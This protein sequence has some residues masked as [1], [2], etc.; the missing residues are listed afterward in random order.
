MSNSASFEAYF[1][2]LHSKGL[3]LQDAMKTVA[4]WSPSQFIDFQLTHQ[5]R[6]P[7][8]RARESE[9]TIADFVASRSMSGGRWPC[10]AM[11]CRMKRVDQLSRFIALYANQ[12]VIPSPI[13]LIPPSKLHENT[14]IEFL[15]ELLVLYAFKPLLEAGLLV[16]TPSDFN[17]CKV[18][19]RK[20]I[21]LKK[22][23]T[24][25]AKATI[26]PNL[27]KI[28]ITFKRSHGVTEVLFATPEMFFDHSFHGHVTK[29]SLR[30]MQRKSK[31]QHMLG[32]MGPAISDV[33]YQIL[34]G[35]PSYLSSQEFDFQLIQHLNKPDAQLTSK[36]LFD[37]FSHS[38]PFVR[39]V[40]IARLLE[41]RL[42]EG[43]SFKVYRDAVDKSLRIAAKEDVSKIKQLFSD[44][45]LPELN[46]IDL[47]I[48]NSRS[49]FAGS[50]IK[51]FAV[52][53]GFLGVGLFAGFVPP[54]VS[55][56]FTALGGYSFVKGAADQISDTVRKPRDIRDNK[57][58]FL[59]KVRDDA[60]T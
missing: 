16:V 34:T 18:H 1:S 12:V 2:F 20:M 8:T 46:K 11:E 17:F 44:D 33:L 22:K 19:A 42:Q 35:N 15:N 28:D 3:G 23:V 39:H 5:E 53:A 14:L 24:Q 49:F 52:G 45:V 56:C 48:K 40:P 6:F 37:G 36:A 30:S 58:Y 10:S 55:H 25:A 27:K 32:A 54:D 9:V 43:E 4:H 57:F 29:T 50:A 7:Y 41:L 59:W 47:S 38:L 51:D 13:T 60:H 21:A 26:K 31:A